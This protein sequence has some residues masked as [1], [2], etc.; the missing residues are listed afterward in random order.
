MEKHNPE[1]EEESKEKL[2]EVLGVDPDHL[3][4]SIQ[5]YMELYQRHYFLELP[6]RKDLTEKMKELFEK[7]YPGIKPY[8]QIWHVNWV[9][10][11]MELVAV[12]LSNE[13]INFFEKVEKG[14]DYK[15]G[16][17][18]YDHFVKMYSK[19]Y[20]V[21]KTVIEYDKLQLNAEELRIYEQVVE[22]AYQEDLIGFK[23]MN[24]RRNE[25]LNSVYLLALRYFGEQTETLTPEQWLH[26][27]IIAGMGY[28]DYFDD[29]RELNYY[30]IE[31][32]MQEYPG[33]DYHTF[34]YEESKKFHEEF[35]Q[36]SESIGK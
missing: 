25:F 7:Q 24:L 6:L 32:N 23:E 1:E 34:R 12:S 18:D 30:L 15:A 2:R 36:W 22:E 31:K 13:L 5:T 19:P 4:D 8:I 17:K 26:Y 3:M 35:T 29:C 27:D 28:E 11:A 10:E 14:E 20:E 21:H 33:L 9:I 16:F